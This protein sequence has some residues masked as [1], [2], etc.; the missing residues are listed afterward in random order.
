MKVIKK[1]VVVI[2]GG[3][4]GLVSA[5][6]LSNLGIDSIILEKSPHWGGINRSFKNK[7]DECFDFGY[8]ALDLNRSPLTTSFFMK[9]L[10]NKFRSYKLN[11]GIVL[12]DHLIDYNSSLEQWPDELKELF[13]RS[14]KKDDIGNKVSFNNVTE[15]YGKPFSSFVFGEVLESYPSLQWTVDNGGN[16][17]D[18]FDLLYP[19]Y[20]P[21][22]P[23]VN[24]ISAQSR[25]YHQAMRNNEEQ[26]V[27]YPLGSN[28]FGSVTDAMVDNIDS[29]I[30]EMKNDIPDIRFVF[31]NGTYEIE[32]IVCGDVEVIGNNYFWCAPITSFFKA[33][34]IPMDLGVE[35]RIII[36]SF[37][38]D[39]EIDCKYHEI[40]VGSTAHKITRMSMPGNIRSERNNL[41]QVEFIFPSDSSLDRMTSEEWKSDWHK[42]LKRLGIV[43]D[44][45]KINDYNFIKVPAG[46]VGRRSFLDLTSEFK[47]KFDNLK[48]N[49][50]TP[51]FNLG[52]ENINVV[53]PTSYENTVAF[54]AE[55]R[56]QKNKMDRLELELN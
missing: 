11:R 31:K 40:L 22:N 53:V 19:W 41:F 51:C 5:T 3:T 49:I 47:K 44:S 4:N 24:D 18:C 1:E 25:S 35:Q 23:N 14:I 28:G 46:Y 7:L 9:T 16:P 20:F 32:K 54:C 12:R 15:I 33:A 26:H 27:I 21:R 13:P 55:L 42:S 8:H 52:P 6:A 43:D 39:Q 56:S 2:G 50:F 10:A 45:N 36:G 29:S 34:N 37:S 30:C 38:F 48:T 17:S